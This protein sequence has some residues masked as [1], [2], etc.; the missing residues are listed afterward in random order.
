VPEY[1]YTALGRG[2][3]PV[4]TAFVMGEKAEQLGSLGNGAVQAVLADLDAMFAG[5]ATPR[6][7]AAEIMDWAKMPYVRGAYSFPVVGGGIAMRERLAAPVAGKL[8][9][10]GEATHS[11]GHSGTMHGAFESA[12]R[13]VG[14]L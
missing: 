4:L 5:A 1:W 11:G 12:S 7:A 2:S 9:F 6:F 14:E 8:F 3:T 10:A 13:V